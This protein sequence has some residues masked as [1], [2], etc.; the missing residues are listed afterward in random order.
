MSKEAWE[1][2]Y[3]PDDLIKNSSRWLINF[4]VR[5][6]LLCGTILP[7]WEKLLQLMACC[8]APFVFLINWDIFVLI[9]SI[10]CKCKG[11]KYPSF[12]NLVVI[13]SL[14]MSYKKQSMS[15]RSAIANEQSVFLQCTAFSKRECG[16]F[17]AS[18]TRYLEKWSFNF[19]TT[20]FVILSMELRASLT[21]KYPGREGTCT[22]R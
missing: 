3:I 13:S 10:R 16:F 6:W 17:K 19:T 18:K 22:I 21:T 20:C 9:A 15:N 4:W 14:K 7:Q 8:T 5:A 11:N 2:M 1:N 12:I